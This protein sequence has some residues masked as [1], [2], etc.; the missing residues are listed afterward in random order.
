MVSSNIHFPTKI[1][2]GGKS[3]HSHF[4]LQRIIFYSVQLMLV[5]L[6]MLYFLS[7]VIFI[8]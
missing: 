7:Y 1:Y 6:I 4:S 5:K 8:K 3:G 2:Q